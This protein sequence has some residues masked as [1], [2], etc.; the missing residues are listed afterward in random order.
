MDKVETLNRAYEIRL[1]LLARASS[2]V[3][4]KHPGLRRFLYAERARRENIERKTT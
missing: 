4:D 3:Y 1:P 2:N